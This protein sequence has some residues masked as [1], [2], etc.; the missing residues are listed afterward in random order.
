M[1]YIDDDLMAFTLEKA[2]SQD[3]QYADVKWMQR[4]AILLSVKNE[5][6]E[7]NVQSKNQE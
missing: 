7:T 1:T 5:I 3:V 4:S 2:Q 6:V